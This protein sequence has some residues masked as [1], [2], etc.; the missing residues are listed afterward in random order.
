M[1]FIVV[2]DS[3]SSVGRPN[4]RKM[5][6]F[7]R[8]FLDDFTVRDEFARFGIV[9]YNRVVD[10][11]TQILLSAYPN[12]LAGLLAAFDRM[13][14]N[15]SGT[16]TGNALNH[17][18]DVLMTSGHREEARDIVLLITDGASS[19]DVAVPAQRITLRS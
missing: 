2:L 13:P 1:D 10:T 4:W 15:G 8:D 9:R 12:D 11:R 17:T 6:K 3:S 5:K 16:K 14:Y 18:A 7:V 19:D